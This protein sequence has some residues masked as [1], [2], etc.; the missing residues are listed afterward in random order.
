MKILYRLLTLVLLAGTAVAQ[1]APAQKI[2]IK[3]QR[4][5][6]RVIVF[7]GGP[8]ADAVTAIATK[9]GIVVIDAPFSK[10]ISQAFRSAIESEFKR[11]D[12]LCLINTHAHS[13]H[14]GGNI[15][16]KDIPIIAHENALSELQKLISDP[17]KKA[18]MLSSPDTDVAGSKQYLSK[19]NP[20]ALESPAFAQYVEMWNLIRND[21]K[22]GFD[23]VFPTAT[24]DSQ[25]NLN[26]DDVTIR[27]MSITHLHSP[28]DIVISI[29]EE[30]VVVTASLFSPGQIP[31]S[32]TP[33][34]IPTD[35][36]VDNWISTLHKVVDTAND[37]TIFFI[38]HGGVKT[39]KAQM[40]QF[41][42]YIEKL[43]G[44]VRR[45]KAE[46]KTVEQTVSALS[47]AEHFPGVAALKNETFRD[48]PYEILNIHQRNI[49]V[50]WKAASMKM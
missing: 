21:W 15:A 40:Q 26:L 47:L 4:I 43:W 33:K 24:F 22:N 11:N 18:Q 25:M 29:P 6:P 38:G 12:F 13:D 30:N 1:Q 10:T 42:G 20:K 23:L 27:L 2:D 17:E 36:D 28:A 14:M 35:K 31:I 48:S 46:G 41:M 7:N 8:W 39:N 32:G 49:E 50:M 45:A 37:Q 19:H 9:K 3:I 34:D 5:S 44:D 16:F